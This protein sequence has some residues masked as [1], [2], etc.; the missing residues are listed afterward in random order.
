MYI[1]H[2]STFSFF[3][4]FLTDDLCLRTLLILFFHFFSLFSLFLTDGL[5]YCFRFTKMTY[6]SVRS[7]SSRL[8]GVICMHKPPALK[9]ALYLYPEIPQYG[10]WGYNVFLGT[11]RERLWYY[12]ILQIS[13]FFRWCLC[14]QVDIKPQVD[15]RGS[16]M[17]KPISQTS[18]VQASI[19]DL[20][21]YQAPTRFSRQ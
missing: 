18:L 14:K 13:F 5:W 1:F 21:S 10:C 6:N 16:I 19:F 15:F 2:Y 7:D 4:F 12:D 9:T 11:N 20:M 3:L 17:H 8:K